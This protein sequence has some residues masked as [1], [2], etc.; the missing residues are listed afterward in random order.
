MEDVSQSDNSDIG[1]KSAG[2]ATQ[3][4]KFQTYFHL[5][6]LHKVFTALGTVN[7]AMQSPTLQFQQ[8]SRM[9][10]DLKE[11]LQNFRDK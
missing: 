8:A 9:T 4:S 7:H 3:L 6:S 11:M 2:F 10:Y 1:A 5:K